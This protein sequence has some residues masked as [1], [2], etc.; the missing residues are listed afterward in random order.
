MTTWSSFTKISNIAFFLFLWQVCSPQSLRSRKRR[1]LPCQMTL[2]PAAALPVRPV[3]HHTNKIHLCSFLF[4][5]LDFVFLSKAKCDCFS[6]SGIMFSTGQA[7]TPTPAPST[8]PSSEPSS[9]TAAVPGT[10]SQRK[11][12]LPSELTSKQKSKVQH[13]NQ[14]KGVEQ[15]ID[16]KQW[17]Q[18]QARKRYVCARVRFCDLWGRK[19]V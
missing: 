7:C 9:P 19:F 11:R 3:T 5:Q 2:R 8:P 12:G 6:W 1:S 4:S 14:A 18:V 10:H 17:P 15:K 16:D 13:T